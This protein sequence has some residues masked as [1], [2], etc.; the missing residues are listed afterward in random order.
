M[1]IDYLENNQIFKMHKNNKIKGF[2]L[3]SSVSKIRS[4]ENA[5]SYHRPN[6]LLYWKMDFQVCTI[7]K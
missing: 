2:C 3:S 4:V 6:L 1:T 7:V 5:L